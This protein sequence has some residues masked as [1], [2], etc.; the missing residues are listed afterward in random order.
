MIV[1]APYQTRFLHHHFASKV[2]ADPTSLKS[3]SKLDNFDREI[4]KMLVRRLPL[5]SQHDQD[6]SV[7]VNGLSTSNLIKLWSIQDRNLKIYFWVNNHDLHILTIYKRRQI[8]LLSLVSGLRYIDLYIDVN[9]DINIDVFY[10][11]QYR[12]LKRH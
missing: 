10:P 5:V 9:I 3:S 6:G 8:S 4:R 12:V 1:G 2:E 7:L 11:V